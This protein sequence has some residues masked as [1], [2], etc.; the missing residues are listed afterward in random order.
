[1]GES[2]AAAP[3]LTV[4]VVS[5]NTRDLTLK[6]LET[7]L[8]NTRSAAM[9]VVVIDNA[10]AD[11]SVEA[12]RSS[13]PEVRCIASPSN[14]GFARANNLVAAE[15]RTPWLLL[16][17][18][19]TETHPG[20]VDNLLAFAKANPSAG[21]VGG[22][23]V[24]PDGSLNMASCWRR[25]TI[26]SLFCSA[27]GL[28][29]L[30]PDSGLFNFEAMGGW[31]R[32]TVRQVDIVVGCLLMI[33][34]AL[35]RELGGFD[36][37]FFMYG[38][39]ADLCLRAAAAGYRPAITPDT[40]IMHL[41]GAS[42]AKRADKVCAVM[43]AKAMLIRRHWPRWKQPIGLAEL[44]LWSLARRIGALAQRQS[45]AGA[46]ARQVWSERRNWLGASAAP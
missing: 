1:M 3:E 45:E 34:T 24:F 30:F 38:E 40:Q 41:V 11:G 21:I 23:T 7:L 25:M 22:R 5:Y 33:S 28:S 8:R 15:A 29:R 26:W 27:T 44:W 19:D 37:R 6:C 14:L 2:R 46:R 35:W 39:D 13:F 42:T 10:S 4:I 17:N 32:D 31:K 16:L 36:E 12:I 9:E 43:K 20:A 18:P